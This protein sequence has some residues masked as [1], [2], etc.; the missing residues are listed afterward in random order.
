[1]NLLRKSIFI[2]L[3]GCM[4]L[5]AIQYN[6]NL[7]HIQPLSGMFTLSGDTLFTAD[8]WFSGKYQTKKDKYF[9][10]V[11]GLRS[12]FI[13]IRNQVDFSLFDQPHADDFVIGKNN[14]IFWGWYFNSYSG[15]DFI[16]TR[17]L[18]EKLDVL[19][20]IQDSLAKHNK[21]LLIVIAPS[22]DN[23]FKED[24]PDTVIRG[25]SSN[26][27]VSL[28]ILKTEGLNYIDFNSY[29]ISLKGKT[30]A[31]LFYKYASHW[32]S[33]GAYL[34]GDSIISKIESLQN[35]K[36]QH[37]N[38]KNAIVQEEPS[39][40]ELEMEND[41]NLVFS[42]NHEP[43][44]HPKPLEHIDSTKNN[45]SVMVV[46][47]SFFW[48]LRDHFNF[49]NY[50]S[51]GIF[52]YYSWHVYPMGNKEAYDNLNME[53]ALKKNDV[54]I[55]LATEANITKLGFDFPAQASKLLCNNKNAKN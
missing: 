19:K 38:W 8:G 9:H 11:F 23:Y 35:L 41:M 17:V 10:D 31:P 18:K 16:G 20:T 28:N 45:L 14:D 46:G 30:P 6:L 13:R 34:A 21:T 2:F 44:G 42:F 40:D 32:T 7:I 4:A 47:D 5:P 3:F 37:I 43:F 36:M 29:F 1:M 33:Y 22:K 52:W 27:K 39:G 49:W 51:N 53:S 24:L 12:I 26:Y 48:A 54:F 15:R 50:F 55:L 25:D